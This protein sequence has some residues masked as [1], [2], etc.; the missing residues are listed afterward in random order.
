M[1]QAIK[2]ATPEAYITRKKSRAKIYHNN[3]IYLND[4]ELFEI[5]LF[6]PKSSR[7]LTKIWLNGQEITASGIILNPGQRIFL[8]R[9]IDSN[10]K[11]IYKTYEVEN[12]NESLNA[13]QQNGNIE[14][15][16]Y[17][18]FFTTLPAFPSYQPTIWYGTTPPNHTGGY[19]YDNNTVFTISNNSIG[20]GG[21]GRTTTTSFSKNITPISD[22]VETG[23]VEKGDSSNQSFETSYGNFNS[24]PT[25]EVRYKILPYSSKPIEVKDLKK[26]CTECG[27]SLKDTFKF[28]PS[29]GNKV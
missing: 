1:Y 2:N 12:T 29:C 10:N 28:C 7:V 5:E 27:K 6:N 14:V 19:Y 18:E 15:K 3:D 11:F 8:E 17:N 20:L 13:I 25:K 16:F 21:L 26:Y 22:S 4:G 24:V 23:R 9:F